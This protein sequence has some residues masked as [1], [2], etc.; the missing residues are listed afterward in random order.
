VLARTDA[1]PSARQT[2]IGE[3]DRY[4]G[5]AQLA[6]EYET[7]AAAAQRP[8]WAAL[9]RA[10]GLTDDQ[11][12]TVITSDAFGPLC[13]ALRT[14]EAHYLDVD[15]LVARLINARPLGDTD[16]TA[17]VLHHRTESVLHRITDRPQH[18]PPRL[19]A[20]LIPHAAGPM[21]DDMRTALDERQRL[22]KQRAVEL[23]RAA[24]TTGAPWIRHLGHPP[25]DLQRHRAWSRDVATIAAYRDRHAITS[26]TPL[27]DRPT[28]DIAAAAAALRRAQHVST[29]EQRHPQAVA[30][31]R[32][33]AP[34][35]RGPSL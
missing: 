28:A 18:R 2:I 14:A 17:A 16:H 30:A 24:L 26:D 13:A 11:A 10:S 19:I 31:P 6:A 7:I 20:G 3:Q 29:A 34:E 5:I 9:I 32:R 22:I 8:R 12:D 35:Q 33:R 21:A 23:A 1:E 15:Q 27:D 25:T 4:G